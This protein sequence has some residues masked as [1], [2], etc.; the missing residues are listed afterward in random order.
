[1]I[2]FLKFVGLATNVK[3]PR[4]VAQVQLRELD[5]IE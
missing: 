3:M 1:M 5:T 2:K 4:P